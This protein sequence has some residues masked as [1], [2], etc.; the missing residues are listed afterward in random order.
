MKRNP[1]SPDEGI[2]TGRHWAA[3]GVY[4]LIITASVLGALTIALQAMGATEKEAVSI[5]FL[6]LA[7]AQL[8]H[9]FN[10]SYKGA[11]FFKNDITRNPFVWGALALCLILVVLAVYVPLFAEILGVVPPSINGWLLI[12]GMSFVP[13]VAGQI[14][15]R[16]TR[17]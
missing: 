8:W 1:R 12:L 16:F 6:T 17:I 11:G 9:V 14:L 15:K 7:L 2:V 10:M 13:L 3:I 5:S 4:G